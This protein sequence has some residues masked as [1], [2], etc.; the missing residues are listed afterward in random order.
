MFYSIVADRVTDPRDLSQTRQIR[1][2]T[3]SLNAYRWNNLETVVLPEGTLS[4][5]SVGQLRYFVAM[6][7][8][9]RRRPLWA[10]G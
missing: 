10:R 4:G 6:A 7:R 8:Q 5:L 2:G 1:T 9:N 3:Y